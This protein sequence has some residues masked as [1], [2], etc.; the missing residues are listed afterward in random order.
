MWWKSGLQSHP[1]ERILD[2]WLQSPLTRLCVWLCVSPSSSSESNWANSWQSK[3]NQSSRTLKRSTLTTPPPTDSSTS[4]RRT[5]P[6]LP[7]LGLH[8]TP[9]SHLSNQLWAA[10]TGDLKRRR[11]TPTQ[12]SWGTRCTHCE[13]LPCRLFYVCVFSTVRVERFLYLKSVEDAV[14]S[15]TLHSHKNKCSF[16]IKYFTHCHLKCLEW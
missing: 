10:R 12:S 7:L 3:S 8:F 13:C 11:F 4:S 9:H 2:T 16:W 5:L 6:D 1:V 14:L 15:P